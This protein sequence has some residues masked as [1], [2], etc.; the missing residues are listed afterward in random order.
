MTTDKIYMAKFSASHEDINTTKKSVTRRRRNVGIAAR[1]VARTPH[2]IVSPM[3]K[4]KF[5]NQVTEK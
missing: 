3:E 2:F 5:T 4:T 1:K